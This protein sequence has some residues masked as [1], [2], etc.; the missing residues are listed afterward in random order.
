MAKSSN[1]SG[2]VFPKVKRVFATTISSQLASVQPM[3]P[4]IGAMPIMQPTYGTNR[5]SYLLHEK[6]KEFLIWMY[7][8]GHHIYDTFEVSKIIKN[9][10]YT[11]E[12]RKYLNSLLI[13][14]EHE[15]IKS[16]NENKRNK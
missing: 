5:V 1:F 15:Y 16:K 2:V 12:N 6:Q 4:P 11:D 8:S 14:Y 9:G 10:R 13:M 3:S 7:N